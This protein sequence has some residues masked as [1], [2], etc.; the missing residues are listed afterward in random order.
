MM[1]SLVSLVLAASL[2]GATIAP[3]TPDTV[4]AR[5]EDLSFL[6]KTLPEKHPNAFAKR[7]REQFL[8]DA[9]S[10]DERLA[11]M[12]DDE[13]LIELSSLVAS[14]G[15]G[16]TSLGKPLGR[17][18]LQIGFFADGPRVLVAP[19]SSRDALGGEVIA[20]GETPIDEAMR[21]L[22]RVEAIET[23]TTLLAKARHLIVAPEVLHGLQLAGPRTALFVVACRDGERR[24][25]SLDAL[26][27]SSQVAWATLPP[28]GDMLRMRDAKRG[29]LLAEIDGGRGLYLAYR[30]CAIDPQAPI[31]ELMKTLLE[32]IDRETPPRVVIDLRSNGGGNSAIL[33]EWIPKLAE[34]SA[35]RERGWLAVLIDRHTFSS[36][37]MNAW[38][39]KRD[40]RAVLYGEPTGGAKNH[41]GE[42]RSFDLPKS[43]LKV[44]HSTRLFKLDG[45]APG[46]VAPDVRVDETFDN[47]LAGRDATL[48]A[49]LAGPPPAPPGP[50]P[51]R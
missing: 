38:Q 3:P 30:K 10:L 44:H 47:Y 20:I 31:G 49:A 8:A 51:A 15:D 28:G 18:P 4:A 36:A 50:P 1:T 25:L 27:N 6:V 33:S 42:V 43:G 34:R 22:A 35:K 48:E 17:Y 29:A 2:D 5:R 16:H 39:L 12:N 26:R 14:L 19:E 9:A 23:E 32:R 11:A 7:T 45:D 13:F 21:R 41:F 37:M 46:P 24:G 40:A